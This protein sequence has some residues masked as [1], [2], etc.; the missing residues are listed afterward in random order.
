VRPVEELEAAAAHA[1]HLVLA[2]PGTRETR[3]LVD[4]RVLA[5]LPAHATVVNVS[6]AS[7]LD[8]AALVAALE[9]GRLRGALLDV[10]D[11]EP[12]PPTSPLWDVEGLWIT[13]HGAYRFPEEE[14]EIARLFV[15]NLTALREGRELRNRVELP[16]LE[17]AL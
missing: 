13:P 11:E 10:H 17:P 9:G 1:D 3:N 12:L 2:V 7:V 15:E 16:E 5:A 8:T 14:A 4:E 6:R